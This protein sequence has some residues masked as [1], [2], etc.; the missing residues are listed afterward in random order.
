MSGKW[1]RWGLNPGL[2]ASPRTYPPYHTDPEGR[3][4]GGGTLSPD[5]GPVTRKGP[6]TSQEQSRS[7]REEIYRAEV[8]KEARPDCVVFLGL[9]RLMPLEEKSNVT[10]LRFSKIP[11]GCCMENT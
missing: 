9:W 8:R 2:N 11:S 10:C 1:Q 4:S 7:E 3:A 6:A 5:R